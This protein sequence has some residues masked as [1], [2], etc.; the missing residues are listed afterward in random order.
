MTIQETLK[1][2]ILEKIRKGEDP[3]PEILGQEEAKKQLITSLISGRHVLI[4]GPPGTGKTT[5]AKAVAKLLPPIKYPKDIPYGYFP[6]FPFTPEEY[7][8]KWEAGPFIEIPGERR[9]V[10]VQGSPDLTVE[11]LIGD[12]DPM[13]AL[14]EGTEKAF[15]PG[16]IFK[17][18][19]GVL[20]FDEL[21]RAPPKVQNALLQVLEEKRITIGPFEIEIP[22]DFV[23]I[24]T[25]NPEEFIGTEKLSDVLLDRLDVVYITYPE[26]T[27]IEKE[28]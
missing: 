15:T 28:I 23:L 10:R 13:K 20:F 26:T 9:F 21:N 24:A 11:D 16:K 3:F 2:I 6:E 22:V 1:E 7:K 19:L 18:H 25:M 27:E 8:E 17:A 12:I 4:I 5:L 14:R